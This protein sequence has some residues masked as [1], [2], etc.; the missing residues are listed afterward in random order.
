MAIRVDVPGRTF[1]YVLKADRA[2]D[3]K[4]VFVLRPL[5]WEEDAEVKELSPLM[6]EQAMNIYAITSICAAEK[7]EMTI[8][9]IGR[10]NEIVPH[11]ARYMHKLTA[12]LARAVHFGVVSIKN[13]QDLQGNPAKMAGPEFARIGRAEEIRE[14]GAEIMRISQLPEDTEKN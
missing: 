11:D 7:R 12:Q 5:A 10:I 2:S 4:T 1:D 6:P 9:E 14:I 8:E 13:L 3:Q